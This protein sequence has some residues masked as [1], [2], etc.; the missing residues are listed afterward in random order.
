MNPSRVDLGALLRLV[1]IG[2]IRIA[3]DAR[4][5]FA[6]LASRQHSSIVADEAQFRARRDLA[7]G[8]RLL[9]RVLGSGKGDRAGL[10]RLP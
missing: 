6:D 9:Q 5:D 10:G 2:E 3:G 1:V 4:I 8:A 7:D